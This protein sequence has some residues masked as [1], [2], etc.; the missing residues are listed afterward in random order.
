M[1]VSDE[2]SGGVKSKTQPRLGCY[3]KSSIDSLYPSSSHQF[4]T[5]ATVTDAYWSKHN[6]LPAWS[7]PS[8]RQASTPISHTD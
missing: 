2:S 1:C 8:T 4:T 6:E 3:H 7:L 5:A